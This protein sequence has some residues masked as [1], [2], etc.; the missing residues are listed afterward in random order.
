METTMIEAILMG[1]IIAIAILQSGR[2]IVFRDR[3]ERADKAF[4]ELMKEYK[5]AKAESTNQA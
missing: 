1:I 3:A 2:A 5:N 4:R